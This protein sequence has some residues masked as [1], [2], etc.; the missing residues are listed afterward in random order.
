MRRFLTM[1]AGACAIAGLSLTFA[2]D[3]ASAMCGCMVGRTPP[4][5]SPTEQGALLNK[6]TVV[7]ML[8][9]GTRTVLSFQND[10]FGP[11]EDFALVVPVPVVLHE[12]DVRT[13]DR[14][15][16]DR[17]QAVAAPHMVELFEQ[18]PCPIARPSMRAMGGGMTSGGGAGD[19][20]GALAEAAPPPPVVVEAQFSEG[21]YDITVLGANDSSA[22]EQWLTSHGYHLPRDA[23][24]YLRPYVQEGMKFFVARVD[25]DRLRAVAQRRQAQLSR[26]AGWMN[27][28]GLGQLIEGPPV[29]RA[30][31]ASLGRFLSPLRIQYESERFALPVRLGL[32]NSMGEQDLVVHILSPEGRFELANYGNRWVPTN[33][34]VNG[35]AAQSFGRFYDAFFGT[36][37]GRAPRRVWTEYAGPVTA[38]APCVGCD[39]PTL[40]QQDLNALGEEVVHPSGASRLEGYTLT[41]LHYRYGANGLPNDLVFRPAPPMAG[42]IEDATMAR[43]GRGARRSNRNEFRV[44]F[45]AQHR[46]TGPMSCSSP[47]RNVWGGRPWTGSYAASQD[48]PWPADRAIPLGAWV[49]DPVRELG[50]R[51]GAGGAQKSDAGMLKSR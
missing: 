32:L 43:L 23:E 4:P 22:L 11:A 49:R 21:E 5:A 18:P 33:V 26:N 27:D 35:R 39:R 25:V 3:Q 37:S 12:G 47:R 42:G 36:L 20:G 45:I 28:G 34:H 13:L 14:G 29:D 7:V 6:A 8:R 15:V 10:Y 44:R 41:R 40:A 38:P 16:F 48:T 46:W 51:R 17:V 30:G 2:T 19:T 1:L 24:R 9:D 50:V 31:D